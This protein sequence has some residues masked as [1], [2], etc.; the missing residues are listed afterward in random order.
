MRISDWSSDVCSSD[1]PLH[2][3]M[4]MLFEPPP[5]GGD[6][7]AAKLAERLKES[8]RAVAPFNHHLVRRRGLHYWKE[9]E[10]F[11]LAHHFVPLSLPRPG[12]IRELLSM[13]SLVPSAPH[14][15]A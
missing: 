7:F 2:I 8:T 5:D 4:L 13:V 14:D 10:E 15:R 11:A 6:D 9:D 3:G 12:H 1:L